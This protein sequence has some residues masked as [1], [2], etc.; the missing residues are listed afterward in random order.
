MKRWL[1]PRFTKLHEAGVIGNLNKAKKEV[2]EV[3]ELPDRCY[4][5]DCPVLGIQKAV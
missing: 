2:L 4:Y 3:G 5:T 1:I